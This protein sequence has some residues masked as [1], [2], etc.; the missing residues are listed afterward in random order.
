VLLFLLPKAHV[1]CLA[2]SYFVCHLRFLDFS[3]ECLLTLRELLV[4]L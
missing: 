4:F 3:D 1:S 2:A